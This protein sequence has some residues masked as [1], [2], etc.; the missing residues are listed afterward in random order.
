MQV[1]LDERLACQGDVIAE[2]TK[3]KAVAD[4]G[5]D[6]RRGAVQE[7]LH[8]AVWT[9]GACADDVLGARVEVGAEADEV[10]GRVLPAVRDGVA[11]SLELEGLGG[12]EA[13]V[14]EFLE[15]RQQPLLTGECGARVRR[16]ELLR[17]RAETFPHAEHAVPRAADGF[18]ELLTAAEVVGVRRQSRNLA[19]ALREAIQEVRGQQ[20]AFGG[21]GFKEM[22]AAGHGVRRTRGA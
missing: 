6:V 1:E 22:V 5:P 14:A 13:S 8:H 17:G 9:G 20:C 18:V 21:D 7:F 16:R 3:A 4:D 2:E 10:D 11:A 15:E 12:L 19:V